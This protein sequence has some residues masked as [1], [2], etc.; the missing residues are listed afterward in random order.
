MIDLADLMGDFAAAPWTIPD[1][2]RRR[3]PDARALARFGATSLELGPIRPDPSGLDLVRRIVSRSPIP[4][5]ASLALDGSRIEPER[6]MWFMRE[7]EDAVRWITL[8]ATPVPSGRREIVLLEAAFTLTRCRR[9]AAVLA[10]IPDGTGSPAAL[11]RYATD[12]GCDGV[13]VWSS[14]NRHRDRSCAH[15][16]VAVEVCSASD[17][18]VVGRGG[19][20]DTDEAADLRQCGAVA[21][22]YDADAFRLTAADLMTSWIA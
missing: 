12:L 3:R 22:Q 9:H 13:V 15:V 4:V 19:I 16:R 7:A 1:P 20:T 14:W 11:A 18:P 10:A 21:V 2:Y 6:L 5:G 17:V 8:D